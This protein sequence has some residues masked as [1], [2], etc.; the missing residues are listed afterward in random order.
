MLKNDQLEGALR[1][2]Y[3]IWKEIY[4]ATLK[5]DKNLFIEMKKIHWQKPL[6]TFMNVKLDNFMKNTLK[7]K[8]NFNN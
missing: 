3:V 8:E 2:L 5:F 1:N 7:M 4:V 6:I